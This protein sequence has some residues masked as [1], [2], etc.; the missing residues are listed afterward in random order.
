MNQSA[1]IYDFLHERRKRLPAVGLPCSFIGDHPAFKIHGYSVALPDL[2]R[3]FGALYNRQSDID[4]VPVENSGKRRCDHTGYAGGLD[5]KRRVF[6]RRT[7]AEIFSGDDDIALLYFARKRCVN[8]FHTVRGEYLR[9]GRCQIS[10]RN[11]HIRIYIFAKTEHPS[12]SFFHMCL[13]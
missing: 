10:C 1:G 4:G 3:S 2:L 6:S 9:L 12:F 7:A 11:N 8:I 5:R 13:L